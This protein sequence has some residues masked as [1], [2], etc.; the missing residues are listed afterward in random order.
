MVKQLAHYA[1]AVSLSDEKF[2][3]QAHVSTYLCLREAFSDPMT[4]CCGTLRER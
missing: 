3:N 4:K 1:V 2:H